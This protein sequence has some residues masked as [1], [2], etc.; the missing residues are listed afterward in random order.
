MVI[1]AFRKEQNHLPLNHTLRIREII[2]F[3]P[4]PVPIGMMLVN[5][6]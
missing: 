6:S 1:E 5:E 3:N 4:N 2:D